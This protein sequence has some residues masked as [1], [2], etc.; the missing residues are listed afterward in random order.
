MDKYLKYKAKYLSLLLGSAKPKKTDEEK[1]MYEIRSIESRI[2]E[3][4]TSIG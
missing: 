3:L 2:G 4:I 1:V